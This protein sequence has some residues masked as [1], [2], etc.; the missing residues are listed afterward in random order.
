MILLAFH[1]S[2]IFSESDEF[3]KAKIQYS[4]NGIEWTDAKNFKGPQPMRYVRLVNQTNETLKGSLTKLGI[5]V[6]NL[7]I[8][9]KMS[10]TS[11]RK[12]GS[13]SLLIFQYLY[14][15]VPRQ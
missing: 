6:N 10:E 14:K 5:S 8:T 4:T 13:E 12:C 11:F 2:D 15:Y 1:L 3:E 9:P 7:K